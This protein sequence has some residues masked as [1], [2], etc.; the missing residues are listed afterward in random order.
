MSLVLP[1]FGKIRD[2]I[3][4]IEDGPGVS[5][6]EGESQELLKFSCYLPN[7]QIFRDFSIF[8]RDCFQGFGALGKILKI[9]P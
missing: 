3:Q 8:G 1:L 9:S 6:S 4:V 2:L 5:R 7:S